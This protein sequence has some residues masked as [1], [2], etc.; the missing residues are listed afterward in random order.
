MKTSQTTV[1][2]GLYSSDCCNEEQIFEPGDNF[3]RCLKCM[4]LC[5]WELVTPLVQVDELAA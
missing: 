1:E 5:E 2:R 4:G 3:T